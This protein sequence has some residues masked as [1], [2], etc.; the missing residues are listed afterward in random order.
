MEI[1][2]VGR[3]AL[4]EWYQML[5]LEESG[6]SISRDILYILELLLS[7]CQLAPNFHTVLSTSAI[8]R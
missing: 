7:G 8:G 2:Q 6:V 3:F 4:Y 5:A 1:P